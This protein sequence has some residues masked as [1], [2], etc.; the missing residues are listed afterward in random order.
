[1]GGFMRELNRLVMEKSRHDGKTLAELQAKRIMDEAEIE[2]AKDTSNAARLEGLALAGGMEQV[3]A[4]ITQMLGVGCP[5]RDLAERPESPRQAAQGGAAA[6]SRPDSPRAQAAGRQANPNMSDGLQR[7]EQTCAWLSQRWQELG[8]ENDAGEPFKP[9]TSQIDI[10]QREVAAMR[11]EVEVTKC[12]ISES[13]HAAA[14]LKG[15]FLIR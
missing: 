8:R 14:S 5:P 13:A 2:S 3:V 11:M 4:I 7:L 15:R 10:L 6:P 12:Q 1:M 9:L